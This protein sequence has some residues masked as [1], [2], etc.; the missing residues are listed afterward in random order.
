MPPTSPGLPQALRKPD[1]VIIVSV[2]K[3]STAIILNRAKLCSSNI[4]EY[5]MRTGAQLMPKVTS[6]SLGRIL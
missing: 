6:F 3:H 2:N 4:I 5:F 1:D